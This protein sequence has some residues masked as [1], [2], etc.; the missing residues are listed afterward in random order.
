MGRFSPVRRIYYA[1]GKDHAL[2]SKLGQWNARLGTPAWSLTVQAAATLVPVLAF[3][4]NSQGFSRLV[5]FNAPI[6]WLFFLLV[7]MAVFVLADRDRG[8]LRPFRVPAFPWTPLVFC[9]MSLWMCYASCTY[10]Y[11]RRWYNALWAI[12]ILITGY[13][14]SFAAGHQ[15]SRPNR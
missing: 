8:R 1:L 4:S 14:V 12:G 2:F 3:G 15:G 7:G 11:E 6:Y 10:A 13:A 5:E 9:A